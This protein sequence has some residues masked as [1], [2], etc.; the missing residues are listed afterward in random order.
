VAST[1]R[2]ATGFS[3]HRPDQGGVIILDDCFNEE[4]PDVSM[5]RGLFLK[6]LVALRFRLFFRHPGIR[7]KNM[8]SLRIMQLPMLPLIVASGLALRPAAA[9]AA[10]SAEVAKRCIHYSYI[11]YPYKR[12]GA[13]PMSGDRQ[14]YFKDCMAKDG[15]VPAPTPSK[16]K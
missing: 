10:P 2:C 16:P 13:V 11:V 12:P 9:L 5:A 15:E 8:P 4:W 7:K 6:G 3:G 14:A 1:T